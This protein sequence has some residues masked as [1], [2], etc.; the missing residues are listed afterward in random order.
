MAR[1]YKELIQ[2]QIELQ[3]EI[4]DARKIEAVPALAECIRLIKEFGF[5]SKQ[6]GLDKNVE[7]KVPAEPLF[8]KDGAKYT[9]KGPAPDWIKALKTEHTLDG[10]LDK[11]AYKTA[12][13]AFR[14]A[15]TA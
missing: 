11:E 12:L 15:K 1:S 9:G 13:E 2:A 3:K 14:I 6:L 7:E 10:K 5:T 4:D 8:E